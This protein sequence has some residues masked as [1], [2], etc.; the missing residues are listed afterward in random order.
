MP[1]TLLQRYAAVVILLVA[2]FG[3]AV[4]WSLNDDSDPSSPLSTER[5]PV[6]RAAP[7]PAVPPA[8]RD[9]SEA[10]RTGFAE[11]SAEAV[12][13]D[14][15]AELHRMAPARRLQILLEL[16]ASGEDLNLGLDFRIGPGGDLVSAPTLRT[17][18]MEWLARWFPEAAAEHALNVF[19]DSDSPDEWAL[20]LRNRGRVH[21]PT[22]DPAFL[23]AVER[24]VR[25]KIWRAESTAGYAE[26][27]DA[28][29]AAARVD[30]VP[31]LLD[32]MATAPHLQRLGAQVLEKLVPAAGEAGFQQVLESPA[33]SDVPRLR[34]SLMARADPRNAREREFL[35]RYLREIIPEPKIRAFF[36]SQFP[37]ASGFVA[38]RL[39]TTDRPRTVGEQV[40]LDAAALTLVREWRSDSAIAPAHPELAELEERLLRDL[41]TAAEGGFQTGDQ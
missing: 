27:H 9:L 11:R 20:A 16:L 40:L 32:A 17:Q 30:L 23:R 13:A 14:L 34:A 31:E 35:G 8:G 22:S 12:V 26:A 4:W 24:V 3:V 10:A 38:H 5:P 1:S 39:L 2:V 21:D 6:G 37:L 7:S 33:Y 19:G 41:E 15:E 36:L 29:V 28:L 18:A 25:D